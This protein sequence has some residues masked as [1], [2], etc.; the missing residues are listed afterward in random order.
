MTLVTVVATLLPAVPAFAG[1]LPG[2]PGFRLRA[3]NGYLLTVIGLNNP[4][5]GKSGVI[6]NVSNRNSSVVYSTADAVVAENSIEAD[7]GAVGS[8]DVHFV[9]SGEPGTERSECGGEQLTFDRGRYEG[10]IDF[11]G[12]HGYSQ[13]HATSARGEAKFFLNLLCA[14]SVGPDGIGGNSPGALLTSPRWR[15]PQ[16]RNSKR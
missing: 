13:A 5:A 1:T 10:V 3:S 6:A 11:E 15:S 16:D 14:V 7:L 8:I 12:E 2:P 9:P 4:K